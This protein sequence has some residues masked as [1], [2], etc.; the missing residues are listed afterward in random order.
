M[1]EKESTLGK[2]MQKEI[3]SR[4]RHAAEHM[5]QGD[6]PS[7]MLMPMHESEFYFRKPASDYVVEQLVEK[8]QKE[9][10]KSFL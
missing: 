4:G 2:K 1:F 5:F 8:Y 10:Q 3:S 7:Y 9:V 6:D